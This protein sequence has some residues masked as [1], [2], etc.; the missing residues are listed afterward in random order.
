M[1]PL[2][3][4]R[5]QG[6]IT[7]GVKDNNDNPIGRSND[8]Y[9]LMDTRRYKVKL[10]NDT[11]NKYCANLKAGKK[12]FCGMETRQIQLDLIERKIEKGIQPAVCRILGSGEQTRIE[13]CFIRIPDP[14][15]LSHTIAHPTTKNGLT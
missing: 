10:A 8:N 2:P 9:L 12:Y 3:D 11:T 6:K 5:M 1:V 14:C 13:S 4:G 15:W 7:G